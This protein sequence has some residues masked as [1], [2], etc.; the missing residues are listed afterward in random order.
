VVAPAREMQIDLQAPLR[1]D[2]VVQDGRRLA[3]RQDGN[4][5]FVRPGRGQRV[6]EVRTVT[7]HY[8]GKPHVARRPP[9]EGG[10]T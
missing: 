2:S 6:G 7:V 5:W 4:A 8:G 3:V 10:F 1:V 9:W